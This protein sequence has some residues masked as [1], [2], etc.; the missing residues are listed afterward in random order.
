MKRNKL[1]MLELV[2]EY[3]YK[4]MIRILT[5]VSLVFIVSDFF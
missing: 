5:F 1:R 3:Q 4:W 2:A